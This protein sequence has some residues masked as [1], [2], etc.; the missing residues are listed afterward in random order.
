M[1]VELDGVSEV[2]LAI[3]YPI[4]DIRELFWQNCAVDEVDG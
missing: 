3:A 1:K 4:Q 2:P